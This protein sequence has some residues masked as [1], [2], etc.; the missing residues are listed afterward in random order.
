MTLGWPLVPPSGPLEQ[1]VWDRFYDLDNMWVI[2]RL[3]VMV[4]KLAACGET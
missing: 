4:E 2:F 1:K 3:W